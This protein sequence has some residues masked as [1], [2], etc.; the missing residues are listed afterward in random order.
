MRIVIIG[1]GFGG[2]SAA[3][4]LRAQ[5]H[6]VTLLE[7]RDK[8]GG[9]AYVYQQDGFTFDA[10]P[11][12]LTAPWLIH[13]LFSLCGK[14]TEE[15]VRLVALDPFYNI[16]FEDGSVFRYGG[17]RAALLAQ[18]RRF[19]AADAAGY[20]RYLAQAERILAAGMAL[21][22]TPFAHVRDMLRV[23]P[24][25][26]RL[27]ADRSV[28][29]LVGRYIKDERL[30]QVFSFHPLLIGGNPYQV[31]A[32]YALIHPLEL[33][34]GVWFAL[35][36]TGARWPRWHGSSWR[37]AERWHLAARRARSS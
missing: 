34:G 23:A 10:G 36:G 17:D 27:R 12:I 3:I 4:R 8:P 1:A 33:K 16:R 7:K 22:D 13:D 21:I 31:S 35:G 11:T 14:R 15:Y 2:L 20:Q 26:A 37:A 30:R 5:G 29:A 18:I 9:R 24:D 25:L 6:T 32:I 19:N 28:A